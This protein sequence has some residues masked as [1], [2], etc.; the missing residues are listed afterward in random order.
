MAIQLGKYKAFNQKQAAAEALAE[1]L[2]EQQESE[3]GF[4]QFLSLAAPLAASLILPGVG[5]ALM[6]GLGGMASGG[7]A[8]A[9]I[10]GGAGAAGAGGTG[11]LGALAGTGTGALSAIGG[12]LATGL[13]KAAGTYAVGELMEDT[14]R[15]MGYGAD[16]DEIDLSKYGRFG[17]K[18]EKEG[19]D[20]LGSMK[21]TMEK[22]QVQSSLMSGLLQGVDTMGGV[23]KMKEISA[24]LG[25][26][27]SGQGK[28]GG[29]FN[30][31][32]VEGLGMGKAAGVTD[33]AANVIPQD[34]Q[35]IQSIID[36]PL[37]EMPSPG[38]TSPLAT[39]GAPSLNLLTGDSTGNLL[40]QLIQPPDMTQGSGILSSLT[41]Y[42]Q[43]I[44]DYVANNPDMTQEDLDK[45]LASIGGQ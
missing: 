2:A 43:E 39:E 14:G 44:M 34:S 37:T 8:L 16:E 25:K 31:G 9:S 41:Q 29:I 3:S 13:G 20:L 18:G 30:P 32:T 38:F 26:K 45:L 4:G 12:G 6:G 17:M 33:L 27:L 1:Q 35:Q 24:D 42:P 21:D 36:T 19:R 10:L 5:T 40:D 15:S 23:D 11:I 22:G 7:G 28:A